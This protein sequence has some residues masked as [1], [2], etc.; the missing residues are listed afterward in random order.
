LRRS[1]SA[2]I[3][4]LLKA[5]RQRWGDTRLTTFGGIVWKTAI[6]VATFNDTLETPSMGNQ[7]PNG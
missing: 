4:Y 7:H 5:D 3:T 1:V 6:H 2:L